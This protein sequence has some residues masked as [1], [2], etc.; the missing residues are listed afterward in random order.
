MRIAFQRTSVRRGG[1]DASQKM[2][3]PTC[4]VA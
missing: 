1:I 4:V 3:R 2:V